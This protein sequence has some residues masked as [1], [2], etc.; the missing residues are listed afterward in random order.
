MDGIDSSWL[1]VFEKNIKVLEDIDER[2]SM[3]TFNPNPEN[4]LRF[5]K[6]PIDDIKVVIVG[7]DTYPAPGVATGRAF[8]VGG[9]VCW[10]EPFRQVSLK[11]IV[12]LLYGTYTEHSSYESF[13]KIREEIQ[14]GNFNLLPPNLLFESWEQQGVLLI[15]CALSCEVG[16]PGSHSDIWKPFMDEALKYFCLRNTDAKFFLWGSVA[17][18]VKSIVNDGRKLYIS[19]HPMM[20][21]SSYS[22]D[23]L[24]SRCFYDTKDEINWIGGV[25]A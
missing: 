10:N 11:N 25:D 14:C 17:G 6:N 15:N 19:R 9:L 18:K 24:K 22:D 13:N 23:F 7:Q 2:L 1:P 4:I 16:I 5:A 12:R 3:C 8:E 21:S 20:C